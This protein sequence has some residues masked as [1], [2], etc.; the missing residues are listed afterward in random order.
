MSCGSL[1]RSPA[2]RNFFTYFLLKRFSLSGGAEEMKTQTRDYTAVIK[3][4]QLRWSLMG[5]NAKSILVLP[6]V[7]SIVSTDVLNSSQE[8]VEELGMKRKRENDQTGPWG[9]FS[10]ITKLKSSRVSERTLRSEETRRSSCCRRKSLRK[11]I[12]DSHN[13]F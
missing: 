5:F 7:V 3:T 8:V 13:V 2:I 11:G 4:K 9:V 10:F 12:A 6:V 1:E